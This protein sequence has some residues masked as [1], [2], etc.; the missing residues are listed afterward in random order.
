MTEQQFKSQGAVL[1]L[2][3]RMRL[4][5]VEG[6]VGHNLPALAAHRIGPG[7]FKF[8]PTGVRLEMPVGIWAQVL[9]RSS[10]NMGGKL[11]SLTGVIDTGY[12][13]ELGVMVHNLYRPSLWEWVRWALRGAPTDNKPGTVTI[14]QDQSLGQIVFFQ[15][16][17][18]PVVAVDE[19]GS[20]VRGA[21]R[22]GS[23]G[24]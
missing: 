18:P 23:T 21:S 6:D 14:A 10:T 2:H 1:S 5:A 22:F 19:L 7:E 17:V 11:L 16:V 15:S 13:G 3:G 20:S 4:P 8:I 12:R 24:H 9:P